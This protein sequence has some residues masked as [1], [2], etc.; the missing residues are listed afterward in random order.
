MERYIEEAAFEDAQRKIE[1]LCRENGLACK[2]V[3]SDPIKLVIWPDASMEGQISMLDEPA[4]RNGQGSVLTIL[5]ADADVTYKISGGFVVS[6][7]LLGKLLSNARKLHYLY[8][9]MFYR[10]TVHARRSAYADQAGGAR[11]ALEAGA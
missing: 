10:K 9:W 1:Q 3:T 8:L 11:A 6:R 4:G 5:F 7:R 2:L